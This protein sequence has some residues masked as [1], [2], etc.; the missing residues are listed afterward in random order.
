VRS[1]NFKLGNWV[2]SMRTTVKRE[3]FEKKSDIPTIEEQNARRNQMR[4]QNYK[5]GTKGVMNFNTLYNR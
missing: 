3:Y 1:S 4:Q 5:F 2:P